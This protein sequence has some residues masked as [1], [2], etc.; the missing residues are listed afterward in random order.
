MFYFVF[1]VSNDKHIW[2]C[3]KL[4]Y[5][6]WDFLR[7]LRKGSGFLFRQLFNKLLDVIKS[8]LSSVSPSTPTKTSFSFP[9]DNIHYVIKSPSRGSNLP[10]EG[11]IGPWKYWRKTWKKSNPLIEYLTDGSENQG[12]WT[13]RPDWSMLMAERPKAARSKVVQWLYTET[14]YCLFSL[15]DSKS[16]WFLLNNWI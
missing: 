1:A 6:E 13:E 3:R 15:F 16:L 11:S 8:P 2:T 5:H 4:L 12:D 7:L 14:F 9:N 10:L